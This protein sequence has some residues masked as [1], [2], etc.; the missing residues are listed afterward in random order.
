MLFYKSRVILKKEKKRWR[1]HPLKFPFLNHVIHLSAK[2]TD[3][4]VVKQK[5]AIFN[6]HCTEELHFCARGGVET[7]KQ[8]NTI[9]KMHLI[10]Q[11]YMRYTNRL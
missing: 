7:V 11:L 2:D 1:A 5:E 8:N 10:I 9:S 4:G 6:L 3:F